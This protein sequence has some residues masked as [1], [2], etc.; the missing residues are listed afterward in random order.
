[1]LIFIIKI[2]NVITIII[3]YLLYEIVFVIHCS[4]C[5]TNQYDNP[6]NTNMEEN[7]IEN[8]EVYC[9][10][11]KDILANGEYRDDR[12][13]VGTYAV[14]GVNM[15]FDLQKSFPILTKKKMYLKTM[16]VELLWMLRGEDNIKF[17]QDNGVKI[18]DQWAH[19]DGHVG[20]MYGY[21]WR[22]WTDKNGNHI[23]Q[24]KQIIDDIQNNPTSR[25]HI[26]NTW[27]VGDLPEMNL[28]PCHIFWQ[29]YINN[30]KELD[31]QMYQRSADTFIGLPYDIAL[32]SLL[33]HLICGVTGYTPGKLK[34]TV[35]DCHIYTN[36]LKQVKE[37]L[38]RPYPHNGQVIPQL[39]VPSKKSID[40]YVIDD[41]NLVGYEPLKPIKAPIAV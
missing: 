22:N 40:D 13:G 10:I 30:N 16:I 14:F 39:F 19:D 5:L 8:E 34:I 26:V 20:P 9:D 24:I 38:S 36:H 28:P 1:V 11:L 2:Y 33:M 3:L 41:F 37:Y 4:C 15:T 27:N 29:L 35:G 7:M 31:L 32:Y 23:D 17:L 6:Y 18:W 21:Q 12:T 25:R